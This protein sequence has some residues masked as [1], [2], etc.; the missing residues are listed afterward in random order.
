MRLRFLLIFLGLSLL[1]C[2]SAR[3][4]TD[5][6]ADHEQMA[7]EKLGTVNFTTSCAVTVQPQF[8][9]AVALMH[10]FQFARAIDAFHT[11]L[12]ADQSCSMAW[13]GIA[14]SDWGN[15]FAAGL[16]SPAQLQH[17]LEAVEQARGA[18]PKTD[19]ERA[20]IE[21]VAVLFT[22]SAH[23]DQTARKLA[24]EDAMAKVSA[25]NPDDV[26]ASI[27][28]ALA[29]AAAADPTDKTY[30][31][32]LKAGKILEAL[33]AQYPDHPGLAHYI[34][35]AYDVPALAPRAAL[36]AQHY[37]EIAPSAAHA[38]HMPSHTFTRI[39]DWQAS[40]HANVASSAAAKS[41]GQ[42]S[43]EMHAD[44][45]L[46]YAYLQSGQD[47]AAKKVVDSVGEVF[48]HVAQGQVVA[49]AA[50]PT[51]ALF[52]RAAIPARYCLER[53]DWTCAAHLEPHPSAVP[54]TDAITWFAKGIAA[55]RLRDFAGARA[56]IASL[57]ENRDKLTQ[58]KEEYW[59][60]QVE[61]QRQEVAAWLAFAQGHADAALAGMRSAVAREDQTEK[62]VITPGPLAPARE[63][64]GELLLE[65][66]RPSEALKEFEAALI[67]EP[68]RFRS[69]YG[70]AES[71]KLS[72][73]RATATKYFLE[74]LQV[75][76][77]AD[78][79]RPEIAEA[80]RAT[81]LN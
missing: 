1:S 3:A 69:L 33:Y 54:Y 44:D 74:L 78:Y 73:D 55:A 61:I 27:F 75:S 30:A 13:W 32:Q 43:D 68:N 81:R 5:P 22:D 50:N 57:E 41:A 4:Q 64:L 79:K 11:I 58:M 42:S 10:S 56:A 45:Y 71:A 25:A 47:L 72:A 52:A 23:I 66:R 19:R 12:A 49:G 67:H 59:A 18:H 20:Y 76:A 35:H 31:R 21:A 60:N 62:S 14:L 34:I 65:L 36:A 39:G 9:R 16:K 40:I 38:L 17:G 53:Q 63:L 8:N 29:I 51:A 24:Y 28:Y 6:H 70:A 7:A 48:A 37:S 15:P 46:V 26:E 80:R 77:H 2:V